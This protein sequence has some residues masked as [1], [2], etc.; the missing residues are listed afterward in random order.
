MKNRKTSFSSFLTVS[1]MILQSIQHSLK[2]LAFFLAL[3][4]L[5]LKGQTNEASKHKAFVDSIYQVIDTLPNDASKIRYAIDLAIYEQNLG[6]KLSLVRRLNATPFEAADTVLAKIWYELGIT[7]LGTGFLDS[8]N[9]FIDKLLATSIKFGDKKG[10]LAAYNIKAHIASQK[11]TFEEAIDFY[12]KA[13]E[14]IEEYEGPRKLENKASILGNLSGVFFYLDDYESAKKYVSQELA[15]GRQLENAEN[16]SYALIR[17]AIMEE[18]LG[19]YDLS[20]AHSQEAVDNLT[21]GQVNDEILLTNAYSTIGSAYIGKKQWVNAQVFLSKGIELSRKNEDLTNLFDLLKEQARV[22]IA[23]GEKRQASMLAQEALELSRSSSDY[24]DTQSALEANLDVAKANSDYKGAL[25]FLEELTILKDSI[26]SIEAKNKIA[27]LRTEFETERKEAEI[28]R[29]SLENE[30]KA[31]K[32][33]KSKQAQWLIFAIALI[34]IISIVLI[35]IQRIKKNKAEQAEQELQ[36][37]ALKKRLTDLNA[38]PGELTLDLED[39]N[40]KLNSKLSE[41]E[42]E[43]LS[44]SIEGKTNKEIANTLFIAATTVKFHLRNTYSKLGVNNRKEALVYVVE[45]S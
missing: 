27:E 25:S 30:L 28:K 22:H 7:H 38:A 32:L 8:S 35:S 26:N 17:M 3:V 31:S 29:L 18:R 34:L 12:F 16:V 9:F 41:R 19:N 36:I 2:V 13:I 14:A 24:G 6:K 33:A 37:E 15:I 23:L 44:L 10:E 43:V 39:L 45:S 42:F 40:G 21:S 11:G 4:P 20:L 1:L 5:L